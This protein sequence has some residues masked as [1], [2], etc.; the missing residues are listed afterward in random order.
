MLLYRENKVSLPELNETRARE[1]SI[2]RFFVSHTS[3]WTNVSGSE[4]KKT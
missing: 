2:G 1:E 3:G 4:I